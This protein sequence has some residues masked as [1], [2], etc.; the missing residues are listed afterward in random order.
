[1]QDKAHFFSATQP[2]A[3]N[4]DTH[5]GSAVLNI[6]SFLYTQLDV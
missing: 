2:L 4:Y 5:F 6:Q 3:Y 1:M